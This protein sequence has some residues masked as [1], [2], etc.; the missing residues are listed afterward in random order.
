MH[1]REDLYGPDANDFRPERWDG[2]KLERQVGWGFMPFHNGPRIC[3]G[4]KYF[5][6]DD[7]EFS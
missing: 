3:L 7:K 2:N 6:N 5:E 1:R 4:S